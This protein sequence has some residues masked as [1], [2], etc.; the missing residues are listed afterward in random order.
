MFDKMWKIDTVHPVNSYY[1][2]LPLRV[3]QTSLNKQNYVS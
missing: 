3:K 2:W 1:V